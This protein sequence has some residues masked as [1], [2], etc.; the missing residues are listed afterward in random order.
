M[1]LMQI[2]LLSEESRQSN[3]TTFLHHEVPTPPK[4]KTL[5]HGVVIK[6]II[7]LLSLFRKRNSSLEHVTCSMTIDPRRG[8][9]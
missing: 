8:I 7:I 6:F 4:R 2:C 9:I 3:Q 5:N 1:A